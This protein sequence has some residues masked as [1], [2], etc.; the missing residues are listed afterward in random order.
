[1]DP[2]NMLYKFCV[3]YFF[4]YFFPMDFVFLNL[5]PKN[6]DIISIIN[7]ECVNVWMVLYTG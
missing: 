5:Q 2:N 6:R 4:N 1:M 3:D 7:C